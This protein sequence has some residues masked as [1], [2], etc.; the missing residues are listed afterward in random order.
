MKGSY[1]MDDLRTILRRVDAVAVLTDLH[2]NGELKAMLPELSAMDIKS[3]AHKDMFLHSLQVLD[4]AD[5]LTDGKAD[6]VLRVA[7]LLHDVGKPRTRKLTKHGATFINHDLVGARMV[8][9]SLPAHGYTETEVNEVA[10]L[11]KLHMRGHS[12][13]DGWT[14]SAIRRLITDAG[15]R[16]QL[17]RLTVLFAADATT[18]NAKKRNRYRSM[19]RKLRAEAI[20]VME[21][22]ARK[23]L[24]P[25]LNGHDVM[26]LFDLTP[27]KELGAIMKFL[28]SDEGII[29]ERDEA[30]AAVDSLIH[31]DK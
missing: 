24:R 10:T 25:A 17:E 13:A 7:A 19:A 26:E 18:N 5:E 20:R 21:Q 14:D 9:K 16:E 30:I 12:F 31:K 4:N 1:V 23:A 22:D 2:Q 8:R 28:N 11:V 3:S 29:L 15:S 6:D 27:G